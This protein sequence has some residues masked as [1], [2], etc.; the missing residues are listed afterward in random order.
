[1]GMDRTAALALAETVLLERMK[2]EREN[3]MRQQTREEII[4]GEFILLSE[5]K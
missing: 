3:P 5:G 1:M 2:A 4:A